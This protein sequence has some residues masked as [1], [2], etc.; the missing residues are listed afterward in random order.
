MII[1]VHNILWHFESM[2]SIVPGTA[3]I[4]KGVI[5]YYGWHFIKTEAIADT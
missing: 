4:A 5:Q 1:N 3:K 2:A